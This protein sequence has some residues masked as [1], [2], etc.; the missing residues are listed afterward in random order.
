MRGKKIDIDFVAKFVTSCVAMSKC[1]EQEI[2]AE[3][4]KDIKDIDKKI[5]EAEEL[6][7]HRSKLCDVISSF[8][9]A[10]KNN[11][12]EKQV[13]DFYSIANK[14]LAKDITDLVAKKNPCNKH[15]MNVYFIHSVSEV[16]NI[17]KQLI[18]LDILK[19][20][21]VNFLSLGKNYLDFKIFITELLDI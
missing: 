19:K 18:K 11:S 15:Y 6:K 14:K 8:D 7:K 20:E 21:G 12:K 1:S 17:I 13:L 2:I 3:A 4:K 16:K 5:K 10:K 9:D